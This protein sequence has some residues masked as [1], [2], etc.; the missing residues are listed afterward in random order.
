MTNE[1]EI[2]NIPHFM[3]IRETAKLGILPEYAL[4]TMVK[5][6]SIPFIMCGSKAMINVDAL[7]ELLNNLPYERKGGAVS[8]E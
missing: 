3:T 1:F 8:E 6:K 5:Q 7:I 2:A 4:R